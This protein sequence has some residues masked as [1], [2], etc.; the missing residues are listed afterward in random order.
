MVCV[1]VLITTEPCKNSWRSRCHWGQT[2]VSP[3]NHVLSRLHIVVI[4]RIWLNDTCLAMMSAATA[5]TLATYYFWENFRNN[6]FICVFSVFS[7]W[8]LQCISLLNIWNIILWHSFWQC[9][10]GILGT[11]C[12]RS[13]QIWK[14]WKWTW[15]VLKVQRHSQSLLANYN[16]HLTMISRKERYLV[17]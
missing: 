11:C 10:E 2:S 6:K 1:C 7:I 17:L 5:I 13:S 3:R 15:K 12:N 9:L 8:S 16:F 4:W 14:I